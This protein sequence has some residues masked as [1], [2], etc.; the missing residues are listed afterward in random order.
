[1]FDNRAQVA[2]FEQVGWARF[3]PHGEQNLVRSGVIARGIV[4]LA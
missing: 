3:L 4:A 1:M 2:T